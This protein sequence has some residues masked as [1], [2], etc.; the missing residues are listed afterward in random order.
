[1][2]TSSKSCQVLPSRQGA[3]TEQTSKLFLSLHA[4]TTDFKLTPR[5]VHLDNGWNY[6]TQ[7]TFY[8]TVLSEGPLTT[9]DF[10]TQGVS[11]YPFYNSAATLASLK[12]SLA[13]MK[14]KYGKS[15]MVVE[16]NWPTSCPDPTY[17]F[18]ADTTSIPF[19]PAGQTT[20]M[21]D[22]ASEIAAEGGSGLFYWEPA[23]IDNAALG[24]SCVYNLQVDD[25]GMVMSSMS[26]YGQI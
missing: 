17:A 21:K 12:S 4:R 7:Q 11:Y 9:A 6:Q 19:S 1:M 20:W 5:T 14:S 22:V 16:T 25:T 8:D 15:V 2:S 26:V 13:S 24:S 3:R 18:P 10:D 23:W